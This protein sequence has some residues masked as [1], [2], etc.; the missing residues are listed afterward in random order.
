MPY[1]AED[2]P[3]P[4]VMADLRAFASARSHIVPCRDS[5][6]KRGRRCRGNFV[7]SGYLPGLYVPM[8][9]LGEH[10]T[11]LRARADADEAYHRFEAELSEA[12]GYTPE[13]TDLRDESGRVLLKRTP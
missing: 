13:P 10:L 6:C 5:R 7:E 8:C 4:I 12:A 9:L 2:V 11:L 3:S 1:F